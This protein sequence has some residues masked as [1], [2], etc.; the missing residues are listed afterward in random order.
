MSIPPFV[1]VIVPVRNEEAFL[2]DTL[3]ALLRQDYPAD[4]FEVIVADGQS[5]DGTVAAVRR[6]QTHYDNL[7][8]I[9][10]P[11]RLA[12]SARNLGVRHARG[13]YVVV[14]DGHCEIRTPHYLRQLVE[15]FERWGVDC[16]GRPQPLDVTG[17]T[18]LQRAIALARSSRLGHNPG[19]FI[20]ADE[21]GFV[22]PHSVGV[23]YRRSVF[24]RVG[25][26]DERFD[27][28]EDVEFNHRVHAAGGRC[29]FDPRL[30]VHYHPRGSLAGLARQMARYGRGRAR[31]LLKHPATFS[32]MPL[33]PALFLGELAASF[34]LGL[35]APPFAALFCLTAL[36]YSAAVVTASLGLALRSRAAWGPF[37]L[38]AVFLTIHVGAG[39]GVLSELVPALLRM[40]LRRLRP[41]A[42]GLQPA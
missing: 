32:V 13:E 15:T 25:D 4:R 23:A 40:A 30:A 10:N 18:P 27:A 36:L 11:R 29:Y 8:L 21:G 17:A 34:G 33:I 16:I 39:G 14:V 6:L 12:S 41:L 24:E 35:V 37:L 31:L 42:R 38:P 22:R 20:Y 3:L 1:T 7:V 9:Y 19:S 26:F 2:A 28:C 5:D